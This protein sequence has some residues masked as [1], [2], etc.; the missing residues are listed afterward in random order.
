MSNLTFDI[1]VGRRVEDKNGNLLFV[2]DVKGMNFMNR[3]NAFMIRSKNFEKKA[4][5]QLN[6][7]EKIKKPTQKDVDKLTKK[8]KIY[9]D[10]VYDSLDQLIGQ[11]T[12][13]KVFVG[14]GK[15]HVEQYQKFIEFISSLVNEEWE[16]E[17]EYAKKYKKQSNNTL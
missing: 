12:C 2:I 6:E 17:E 16:K 13:D 14:D 3:F 7:I 9:F 4:N 11:G 5:E 10:E 15:Y 1:E 8:L